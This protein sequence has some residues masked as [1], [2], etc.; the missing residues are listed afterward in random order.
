MIQTSNSVSKVLNIKN[1]T[2]STID[3]ERKYIASASKI[4]KESLEN[5]VTKEGLDDIPKTVIGNKF[6]DEVEA[7][8]NIKSL[9]SND[10]IYNNTIYKLVYWFNHSFK[11]MQNAVENLDLRSDKYDIAVVVNEITKHELIMYYILSRLGI[12]IRIYVNSYDNIAKLDFVVTSEDIIISGYTDKIDVSALLENNQFNINENKSV[13]TFE[14][15][16]EYFDSTKYGVYTIQGI[17]L[18]DNSDNILE[19]Y[20]SKWK[21]NETSLS[22]I[23]TIKNISD[24]PRLNKNNLNYVVTTLS[25][26]IEAS[27]GSI[28]EKIRDAFIKFGLEKC[29][30]IDNSTIITNKL[31]YHIKAINYLLKAGNSKIV[32]ELDTYKQLDKEVIQILSNSE[33]VSILI[34]CRKKNENIQEELSGIKIKEIK[35]FPNSRS[36]KQFGIKTS[37]TMA[38]TAKEALDKTL[39][40]GHVAG[41]YRSGQFKNIEATRFMLTFPEIK[42]WI[43]QPLYLRPNYKANGNTVEAPVMFNVIEGIGES[44]DEYKASIALS[45]VYKNTIKQTDCWVDDVTKQIDSIHLDEDTVFINHN[46]DSKAPFD[47]QKKL[48]N[49]S[50][51]E[52]DVEAVSN[53]TNYKYSYLEAS[54]Q[55]LM[56]KKIEDLLRITQAKD[57]KTIDRVL[58]VCLNLDKCCMLSDRRAILNMIQQNDFAGDTFGIVLVIS[59]KTKLSSAA[60]IVLMYMSMLGFDINILVPT[61]YSIGIEPFVNLFAINVI[62]LGHPILDTAKIN[63]MQLWYEN[64]PE[65]L[66]IAAS[67]DGLSNETSTKKKGFFSK[68]FS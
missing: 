46:V 63:G 14:E 56:I 43:A 27:K 45:V 38:Y 32:F 19:S 6:K 10:T 12:D 59:D 35:T 66:M 50:K 34:L 52:L 5:P 64:N 61:G 18:E 42:Q 31:V 22:D 58:N 1:I 53:I 47:K 15:A 20:K 55:L 49:I 62:N 2:S 30:G 33:A 39:F 57:E 36:T 65:L 29:K 3:I 68:L 44:L 67:Q 48:Y 4:I 16:L 13:E 24:I 41:L 26:F 51:G 60:M 7:V 8:R 23:E 37:A 25:N 17:E 21:F 54:K 11:D 40:N 28:G 9:A